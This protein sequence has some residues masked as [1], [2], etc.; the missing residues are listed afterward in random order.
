MMFCKV[1]YSRDAG[2]QR[3]KIKSSHFVLAWRPSLM[4][5]FVWD[6]DDEK[7]D[8]LNVYDLD[9]FVI[10]IDTHFIIYMPPDNLAL[11]SIPIYKVA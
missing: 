3:P 8:L 9:A 10:V 6:D 4:L 5:G 1:D 7:H 2:A 11:R